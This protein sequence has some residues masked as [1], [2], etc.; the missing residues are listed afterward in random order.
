MRIIQSI[1]TSNTANLLQNNMGWLSPEYNLMSWALSCLQLRQYYPEV[2]LYCDSVG[3]KMLIDKLQL[4]YSEV[5]CNLDVLNNYN[6]E[7]WAL[8]KIKAYSLQDKPFLH[9]DGDVY[10]WKK[11]DDF[12]LKSG[13]IAQNKDQISDFENTMQLLELA[14]AYFPR[15][16][17]QERQSKNPIQTYNAGIY[18]GSDISFFQ[19][20]T[21]KAFTFVDKN[22][23]D[24]SKIRVSD[25]N[26]FFEQY[27][28][29]CLAKVQ[30]KK[31]TVLFSGIVKDNEYKGFG[32]F[33][34]VPFEKQYL[35]LLSD[36]KKSEYMCDELANRL[37][38]DYPEYY[39]RIIA[40][41]K[42]NKIPLYKNYYFFD[43][44]LQKDLVLS[45]SKLKSCFL[46]NSFREHH[47]IS[48]KIDFKNVSF[49]TLINENSKS[50]L[51]EIQ[52]EDFA[53]FCQKI[54]EIVGNKFSLLS[55]DYLYGRDLNKT[56]YSQI[57]FEDKENIYLKK[58]VVDN[59]FEIIESSYDWS[60]YFEKNSDVSLNI[61]SLPSNVI[62]VIHSL[63]I[64]ECDAVGF[65]VSTLDDLD[66]V[67][68]EILQNAKTVA[69]LLEE[70]K[71]Y[72]DEVDLKESKTEFEMLIFKKI[73]KA[74]HNKSIRVLV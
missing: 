69:T 24:L 58:I 74:I 59:V 4:P 26:L 17:I 19:E 13:L 9:I 37:R 66:L 40:L 39:Y 8:S 1:W 56:K 2:V 54:D 70:L 10:V 38:Q 53:F 30:N 3:A 18:G 62:A 63:I 48:K 31:V 35:H 12:L 42:K 7:L 41:F 6:P 11:F 45:D 33:D 15:E 43:M 23:H 61:N 29:Y 51:D 73:K 36:Y 14:F 71:P 28:F 25:F 46:N 55:A 57:L 64:P 34:K 67:V 27:L 44:Y 49:D 5:V 32:E 22:I 65:S 21:T 60:Y 52:L 47:K 50:L 72:F 20:Y 16:I 68:L